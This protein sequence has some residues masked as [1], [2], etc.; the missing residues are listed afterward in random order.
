MIAG[1]FNSMERWEGT[2]KEGERLETANSAGGLGDGLDY[3]LWREC[4][5]IMDYGESGEKML[6]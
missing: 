4:G 1:L 5:W 3:G 2:G 6:Y